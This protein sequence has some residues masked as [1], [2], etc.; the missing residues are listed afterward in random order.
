[1]PHKEFIPRWAPSF[2]WVHPCDAYGSRPLRIP[3][4]R[5]VKDTYWS[6]GAW[7]TV[8]I[9]SNFAEVYELFFDSTRNE[10]L[11]HG[12]FLR[13]Y[14]DHVNRLV[15]QGKYDKDNKA[16]L[17]ADNEKVFPPYQWKKLYEYLGMVPRSVREKTSAGLIGLLKKCFLVENIPGQQNPVDLFTDV[18][19]SANPQSR[20]GTISVCHFHPNDPV[21][22]LDA[23]A[24][25][26]IVILRR[27][28]DPRNTA[29]YYD[30]ITVNENTYRA[31]YLSYRIGHDDISR[32]HNQMRAVTFLRHREI[33]YTSWWCTERHNSTECRSQEPYPAKYYGGNDNEDASIYGSSGLPLEAVNSWEVLVYIRTK[34]EM[35]KLIRE[36]FE[37]MGGNPNV[38]CEAHGTILVDSAARTKHK[39]SFQVACNRRSSFECPFDCTSRICKRHLDEQLS[40]AA[41][42]DIIVPPVACDN[43]GEINADDS[44]NLDDGSGSENTDAIIADREAEC[45]NNCADDSDNE[46]GRNATNSNDSDEDSCSN[47]TDSMFVD[48]REDDDS[49]NFYDNSGSE[50]GSTADNM[51]LFTSQTAFEVPDDVSMS[52]MFLTDPMTNVPTH[53]TDE[54]EF[55]N[56]ELI[57]PSTSAAIPGFGCRIYARNGRKIGAHVIYNS[58]GQCLQRNNNKL[59]MSKYEKGMMLGIISTTND[60]TP[61]SYI[62]ASMFPNIFWKGNKDGSSVGSL[63]GPLW[64]DQ[65]KAASVNIAGYQDHVRARVSNPAIGTSGDPRYIFQCFDIL[66]NISLRGTDDRTVLHR[67]LREHNPGLCIVN[68]GKA[69]HNVH[70]C[71]VIDS[72]KSVNCLSSQLRDNFPTY[73]ITMTCNMKEFPSME[74]LHKIKTAILNCI[75]DEC[76]VPTAVKKDIR[77]SIESLAAVQCTR[78]WQICIETILKYI[79]ESSDEVLGKFLGHFARLEHQESEYKAS[80]TNSHLHLIGFVDVDHDSEEDT[81]TMYNR[82]RGSSDTLFLSEDVSKLIAQGIITDEAEADEL[83]EKSRIIQVH[84]CEKCG[85]RCLRS[86]PDGS[87][88]CRYTDYAKENPNKVYGF[89]LIQ[90]KHSEKATAILIELNFL[91]KGPDGEITVIDRRFEAGKHVYPA[92]Y[93]E[94]FSPTNPVLFALTRSDCNVVVCGRYMVA[95]YLAKYVASIDEVRICI[96][97]NPTIAYN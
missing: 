84:C 34:N 17:T 72:R 13:Y 77:R 65:R 62:E 79:T 45:R 75:D 32:E 87:T 24:H 71:D 61:I 2:I 81:A 28:S 91:E 3:E 51:N 58:K 40:L 57:I 5:G 38:K 42:K 7:L 96:I 95:R 63:T 36:S 31:R 43:A 53:D 64:T 33:D 78:T 89:I 47:R 90:M 35:Q 19:L 46:D 37:A 56:N 20:P 59:T 48:I 60:A 74:Q 92:D 86:L 97:F 83:R 55:D 94:H 44:D 50:D 85:G 41:G 22:H 30:T 25:C 6:Y 8:N 39:C 88:V 67:G 11:C 70:S 93:G 10:R 12:W 26:E 15:S 29:W 4:M 18:V 82:I 73:F 14:S 23:P 54:Q 49:S 69:Q 66:Q 68:E 27:K 9:V 76:D 1:M 16:E 21:L 80:G 52:D